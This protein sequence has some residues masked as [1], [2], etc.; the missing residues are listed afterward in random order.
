MILALDLATTTGWAWVE[1]CAPR[2]PFRFGSWRPATTHA[3][4]PGAFFALYRNWLESKI[5][6]IGPS[7]IYYERPHFRGRGATEVCVGLQTRVQEL[8]A[9][10][11]IGHGAVAPATV[12]KHVTGNG[13]AGKH[14]VIRAM[15]ERWGL[16]ED[17]L[18]LS[19]D[20]EADALAVLA[21]A[22]DMYH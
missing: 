4:S 14:D 1:E 8:A 15:R 3:E 7:E 22:M 21:W 9:H 16:G 5:L 18:P 20:N 6:E 10:H 19:A 12:K 11:R 2:R 17:D 13:R